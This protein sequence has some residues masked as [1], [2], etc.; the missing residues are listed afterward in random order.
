MDLHVQ[1]LQIASEMKLLENPL[2]RQVILRQQQELAPVAESTTPDY[3]LVAKEDIIEEYL[4]FLTVVQSHFPNVT[5]KVENKL[6]FCLETMKAIDVVVLNRGRHQVKTMGRLESGGAL[7]G[8][9]NA[10]ETLVSC[11][12]EHVMLNFNGKELLIENVTL[13]AGASQCA[14]LVRCG[15]VTLRNCKLIGDGVSSTHQG[16]IVLAN[17]A[18]ELINCELTR[19]CTAIV[20]NSGAK[21]TLRKCE[22]YNV[23]YGIKIYDNCHVEAVDSSF[24]DCS[25]YGF[26]VESEDQNPDSMKKMGNFELLKM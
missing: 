6:S 1:I 4:K 7:R 21:I 17:G 22:I 19:F 20:G 16:I 24:C 25:E 18:L 23:C 9:Y 8:I 12:N 10:N 3:W 14:L 2:I 26:C 15:K 11:I 13:D 5:A